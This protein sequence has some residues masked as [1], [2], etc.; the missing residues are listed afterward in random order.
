MTSTLVVA[1]FDIEVVVRVAHFDLDGVAVLVLVDAD[2]AF[3]DLVA[4]GFDLGFNRVLIPGGD[5]DVGVG[6]FDPQVGLAGDGVRLGPFVSVRG[7]YGDNG[8]S[9]D[10]ERQALQ[11]RQ[12]S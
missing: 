1:P 7:Q 11:Q 3:A 6:R 5:A 12:V 4:R 10:G 2:A 8:N 9:Q